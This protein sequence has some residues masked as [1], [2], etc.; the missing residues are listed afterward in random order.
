[1]QISILLEDVN[2]NPPQFSQSVYSVAI[3]ERAADGSTVAQLSATD[4]DQ[5][6]TEQAIDDTGE[7]FED[8]TYVIDHGIFF[9]SIVG[10][11]EEGKFQISTEGGT[12]SVSPEATFD[13][14]LQDRYNITVAATDAP[15]LNSTALVVV[16]ILDSNDHQ[17]QILAPRGV[18]LTLSEY[19]PTGLIILDS[20]N[21]TDEDYGL[22]AEIEFLIIS[23]D[24]TGSFSIDPSTGEIALTASLD[25]EGGTGE[26]VNLTVA[27]RDRGIPPLQDTINVV[28][29]IEDV[30][31]FSPVFQQESFEESVSEGV[32]TGLSVL[33]VLAF[34]GDEG[35]GGVVTHD[36]IRGAEGKFRIDP[37]TGEIFT[38]GTLDREEKSL[39]QLVIEAVDNPLNTSFQLSSVINVTIAINDL[40][41]N[42]PIFNQT[43]YEIHILDNLRPGADVIQISA[44]DSDEG[45]NAEIT[46]QFVEPLP[47][48]S[49]RFRIR[50]DSG[51]VRVNNR[52][53]IDIQTVYFYVIRALD[54]G[55]PTLQT[56]VNLTIYIHDVDETPPTFEQEAY[57]ETL[58]ETVDVGSFVL[59][60]CAHVWVFVCMQNNN[61]ICM[62]AF[63]H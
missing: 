61:M 37:Q 41:D 51:L 59:Q 52:P 49:E 27:A 2:D 45:V 10:G 18:N 31:D 60:V 48:N 21:A 19:T 43:Y 56:D 13:V 24:D 3:L 33:Q 46:Y 22:N 54:G 9:Y 38:N 7:N 25:R 23:G 44:S 8:L 57:N 62:Y 36:I 26:I 12:I 11:N 39:Y 34:D 4:I 17:P 14:A 53:R 29:F 47:S 35:P 1:M 30:N 28:I 42:P 63:I 5:V 6:L 58:N 16:D 55:S 15:G 32:R 50:D 20:I 40:N